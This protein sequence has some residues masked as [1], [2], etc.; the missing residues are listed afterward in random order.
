MDCANF[1][2]SILLL[3]LLLMLLSLQLMLTPV[4][5]CGCVANCMRGLLNNPKMPMVKRGM[6]KNFAPHY[7]GN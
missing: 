2:W 4:L 1:G 3:L 6:T 5:V 7:K